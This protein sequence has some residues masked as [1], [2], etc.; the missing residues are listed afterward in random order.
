MTTADLPASP[1]SSRLLNLSIGVAASLAQML[2][3]IP[4]YSEN[5]YFEPGAWLGVLAVWLV[6]A[7]AVFVFVVPRAGAVTGAV[8]GAVA[9]AS[10]LIFWAG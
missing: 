9:L 2:M 8:L 5:G 4:G 1:P 3:M 10:V 7:V 6:V